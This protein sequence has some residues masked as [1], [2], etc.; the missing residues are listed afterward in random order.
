MRVTSPRLAAGWLALMLGLVTGVC[1]EARAPLIPIEDLF[2]DPEM[3]SVQVAPDGQHLAF[4]AKLGTGRIGI[5]LMDLQ[6]GQ[7]EALV[8]A[9]DE[10]YS[11]YFW[12]GSD[13]IVFGGDIGGRESTA[14]RSISL[15]KRRV[16]EL[17]EAYKELVADRANQAMIMDRL[18]FDPNHILIYGNRSVGSW[19]FRLYSLDVRTG[20]RFAVPGIDDTGATLD[21]IVDNAG[22]V[23]GR[24]I[25]R[26]GNRIHEMRQDG[27]SAFFKV[28]ET[29]GD[30]GMISPSWSPQAFAKD[31]DTVYVLVLGDDG[32]IRLR[33]YRVSTR[34]FTD[35]VNYE[36][37]SDP[38]DVVMSRDRS[39]LLGIYYTT[40]REHVHW[41][42][43]DRAKLQSEI[44]AALPSTFNRVVSS[45]DDEKVRVI[46]ATSDVSP[47]T[48][49]LLDQSRDKPRLMRIGAYNSKLKESD[50][51]PMKPISYKAR[52]GLTIHGYL[53]LPAGAEGKR[54]PLIIH[55]HGG[56][57]GIRDEWGYDPEVQLM[58][59][60]GYAVLQPNYRGSGGYGVSFLLAG[61]KEWG[62]KMQDDLT[63]G[64][65]WAIAQGIADP[66][67]VAIV[68]A[69][70][71]GYAAL[72]GVTFTPDL[73]CCAVNYVGVSDLSI[74]AGFARN[75]LGDRTYAKNW[76]GDDAEYLRTRSPVNYVQNIRVPTLHGYGD[77]D[78]RVD[79]DN[80][81]RL[82]RQL[83]KYGKKYT[84]VRQAEEGHGFRHEDA[85]VAFYREVEKFLAANIPNGGKVEVGP[86]R[87]LEMPAKKPAAE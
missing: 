26:G 76:I 25:V 18:H 67:R 81:K 43:A 82:K 10:N 56:P 80:W 60:R 42:D 12:K 85:R 41:F 40:D 59:N 28:A 78:P 75:N 72:A 3:R 58:A 16:T 48:Y 49:Y 73:Y 53:T 35:E 45:S 1:A 30:A 62:G 47:G 14:L 24:T 37:E 55:P 34:S 5:A 63:D 22:V 39:K 13:R 54:V 65:K 64:V 74:I 69:S 27:K 29:E 51:R 57:Y 9:K 19:T 66:D 46:V 71:G 61:R 4:L 77:N 8:A 83:D 21:I 68:G 86:D 7:A 6:T 44:D 38:G 70:Y 52:D 2:A 23:R 32:E 31:N 79:I 33:S 36:V 50:L 11:S 17:A 20:E 87:V 84:F 15:S